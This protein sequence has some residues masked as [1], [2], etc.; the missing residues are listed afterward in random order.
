MQ[1]KHTERGFRICR[2][3]DR[4]G[5]ECSLQESSLANDTCVWLGIDKPKAQ[6]LVPGKGWQ[7]VPL[8]PET[9]VTS[10]MHLTQD[11]VRE[12]LPHLQRFVE[13]GEIG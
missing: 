2:F 7:D 9:I 1:V 3:V 13:T 5:E 11:Q 12:L 10:R 8:P 4:Y 6:H